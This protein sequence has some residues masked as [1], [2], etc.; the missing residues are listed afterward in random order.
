LKPIREFKPG[1]KVRNQYGQ[2]KTV[3]FQ[4]GVQVWLVEDSQGWHHPAKLWPVEEQ[5]AQQDAQEVSSAHI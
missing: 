3:L 2:T 4:R 1:Q 5:P